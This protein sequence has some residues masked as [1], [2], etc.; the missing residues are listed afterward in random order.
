MG[1]IGGLSGKIKSILAQDKEGQVRRLAKGATSSSAV[2]GYGRDMLQVFGYDSQAAQLNVENDLLSRYADYEEMDDTPELSMTLNIYADE[3]MQ[4]DYDRRS[5]LWVESP[6]RTIEQLLDKDL[7]NKRLRL[8]QEE[9]W[10]IARTLIKYG[11]NFEELLVDSSGVVGI[12]HLP[13]PTVRR[14]EGPRGELYGFV[15][16]FRGR[17]GYTPAD[18]QALLN[19]RF[20]KQEDPNGTV[21][22]DWNQP[23][24]TSAVAFEDWEVVHFRYRGKTRRSIYGNGILE[25]GRWIWK[26]LQLLEDTA[27]IFRLQ[28][29]AERYAFYVDTGQ[30]PPR[31]AFAMVN[32]VRQQYKKKRFY[33][34]STGKLNL[35]WEPLSQLDDFFI[36]VRNG[37]ESTRIEVL[38]T[39]QWQHVEDI[40]YFRDKLFS[41]LGIPKAYLAQD[42]G[43]ARQILSNQDVVVA[44]RVLQFQQCIKNGVS[45]ICRIHLAALGIDPTQVD[46]DVHMA[47]P[48]SMYEL[49]QLEVM[50]A[51]AD[52]AGRMS[53]FVSPQWILSR[54]F[55]LKDDEIL[56]VMQ[57]Q[58]Q[59]AAHITDLA[60]QNEVRRASIMQSAPVTGQV[61]GQNAQVQTAEDMNKALM[62]MA[63]KQVNSDITVRRQALM[64]RPKNESLESYLMRGDKQAEKRLDKQLDQLFKSNKQLE[65]RMREVGLFLSELARVQRKS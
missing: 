25:S 35:K 8:P 51:R 37:Q 38:G 62:A 46:Y 2:M 44:R 20:Q 26:R 48:T 52:L 4:P 42:S 7:I 11:S 43:V 21:A 63:S 31:E 28:K 58:D 5:A 57:Q 30:L 54:I 13:A 39:P 6:D 65:Q 60:A 18:F 12:N 56:A 41:S 3:I 49:A 16:D 24:Q 40:E 45:R 15:Q 19:R 55:K 33:D 34:P 1:F 47:S 36:P 53:T 27:V 23:S 22:Q 50:N 29:G 61:S 17:Y 59:H 14:V 32:K 10:E 64:E 9:G